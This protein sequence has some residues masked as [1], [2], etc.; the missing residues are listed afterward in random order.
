MQAEVTWE[1]ETS[2]E[3]MFPLDWPIG[4]VFK[5]LMDVGGPSPLWRV[6]FL[7]K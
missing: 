1:A 2:T 6:L 3:K 4:Y 5:L 7:G